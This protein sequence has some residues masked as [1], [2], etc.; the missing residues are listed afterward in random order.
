M[1]IISIN[2]HLHK[3][4]CLSSKA[5]I[6]EMKETNLKELSDTIFMLWFYDASY[7]EKIHSLTKA[8]PQSQKIKFH[9]MIT[10]QLFNIWLL[11][12]QARLLAIM[13][14]SGLFTHKVKFG[15][16]FLASAL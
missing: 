3:C 2:L 7:N 5:Y 11:F 8:L 15:L 9:F 13:C 10:N 6:I 4:L 12:N 16:V 1:L 14:L